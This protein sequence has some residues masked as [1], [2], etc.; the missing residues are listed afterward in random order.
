MVLETIGMK[1]MCKMW[2]GPKT[3][4]L[5]KV[6]IQGMDKGKQA[7]KRADKGDESHIVYLSLS[8]TTQWDP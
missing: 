5:K 6:Y 3:K 2:K 8:C 7:Y 4:I 1:W